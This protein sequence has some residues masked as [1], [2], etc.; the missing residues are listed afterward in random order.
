MLRDV[1]TYLW[2]LVLDVAKLADLVRASFDLDVHGAV[3]TAA[4]P[5]CPTVVPEREDT[6]A[7]VAE[8]A[9]V[10]LLL[11]NLLRHRA[12]RWGRRRAHCESVRLR[13]Q[14]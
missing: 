10:L 5:A 9:V 4:A 13:R 12:V 6:E 11:L 8:L 1:S 3:T 7:L 14:H 2:V